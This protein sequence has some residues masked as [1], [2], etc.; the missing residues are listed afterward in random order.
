MLIRKG[1]SKTCNSVKENVGILDIFLLYHANLRSKVINSERN[2]A[3]EICITPTFS[4]I[5]YL[6]VNG[7]SGRHRKKNCVKVNLSSTIL[8]YLTEV[9]T[10]LTPYE[11][12]YRNFIIFV[13]KKSVAYDNH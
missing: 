1:L 7:K 4:G 8:G 10:L 12:K 11:I 13:G 2:G 3:N 6:H 9:K 5:H